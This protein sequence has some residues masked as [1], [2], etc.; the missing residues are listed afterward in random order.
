MKKRDPC[1]SLKLTEQ[2]DRFFQIGDIGDGT[3]GVLHCKLDKNRKKYQSYAIIN[4]KSFDKFNDNEQNTLD[5]VS[6]N[7]KMENGLK[8]QTTIL[9]KI[10]N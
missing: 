5:L 2:K 8:N 7:T 3:Q 10:S 4:K 6:F 1:E 9:R